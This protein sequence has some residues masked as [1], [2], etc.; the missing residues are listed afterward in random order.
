MHTSVGLQSLQIR[1]GGRCPNTWTVKYTFSVM[2][3]W[4]KEEIRGENTTGEEKGDVA[5]QPE[6]G[7]WQYAG[8]SVEL[9][10]AVISADRRQMTEALYLCAWSRESQASASHTSS[11]L[12]SPLPTWQA[13]NIPLTS[14]FTVCPH[15][16]AQDFLS[17]CIHIHVCEQSANSSGCHVCLQG[18][19]SAA[20]IF[21]I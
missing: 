16:T 11:V 6:H 19:Y 15:T 12:F 8:E 14:L 10:N 5:I 9:V 17:L 18:C 4:W 13:W 20:S 2:P 3:S 21:K 1:E 7:F